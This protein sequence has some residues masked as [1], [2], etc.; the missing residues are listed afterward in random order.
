MKINQHMATYALFNVARSA[1]SSMQA[2]LARLQQEVVTGTHADSGLVLG[3]RSEELVSFKSDIAEL[4]R[5]VDTNGVIASRL[6]MTQTALDK[7]N[8]ISD[9]LVQSLGLSLGDEQQQSIVVTESENA[10]EQITSLLNTQ[11][12]GIHIFGGLNSADAPIS[13]HV[14]GPGETAFD[15]AFAGHFGFAKTDAAAAGI[16][17]AQMTDFLE[18]VLGPQIAG[19]GW[20]TT[21]SAA[22]D[23]VITSRIG[24]DITTGTSVSANEDGFR[25]LMLSAVV[26]REMYNAPLSQEARD[27]AAEFAITKAK[28]AGSEIT[29]AQARVGLIENRI[30][31]QNETMTS[32]VDV[33]TLLSNN[34]E[35][36]DP[37][38]AATRVNQLITQIEASYAT[39]V[40][41]QQLSVL[42]Y[43]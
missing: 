42:R 8:L 14:G 43:L 30:E 17:G 25:D 21:Y 38:E 19:A 35:G 2:E 27:S 22:T 23:E 24:P 29:S 36:V 7:L 32:Q 28:S 15:A 6:D 26:A 9:D 39:T 12:S 20:T 40:R 41:I 10:I 16:T 34:L 31:K 37:Y 11:V 33:L 3:A 18:N 5:L 4:E 13:T 1:T